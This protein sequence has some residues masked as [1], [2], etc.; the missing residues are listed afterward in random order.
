MIPFKTGTPFVV[1]KDK[2]ITFRFMPRVGLEITVHK[3]KDQSKAIAEED[4]HDKH[5]YLF[6]E[7]IQNLKI[8][9][10]DIVEASKAPDIK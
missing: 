5:K 3:P 4:S 7:V 9:V 1:G 10:D 8:A 2:N 6:D